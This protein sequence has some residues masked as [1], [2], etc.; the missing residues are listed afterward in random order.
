MFELSL[1][2][3]WRAGFLVNPSLLILVVEDDDLIK[4]MVPGG[5]VR[6]RL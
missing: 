6:K 1:G 4:D 5:I 2:C 3:D